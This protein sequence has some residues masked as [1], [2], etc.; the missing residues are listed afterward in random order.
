MTS[1][2]SAIDIQKQSWTVDPVWEVSGISAGTTILYSCAWKPLSS[3]C[4]KKL[5]SSQ[6]QS[7]ELN[8]C[9]VH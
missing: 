4:K 9:N 1:A 5:S 3:L 8:I 7:E 6:D 2:H